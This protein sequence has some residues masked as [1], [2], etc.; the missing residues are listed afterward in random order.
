MKIRSYTV[1]NTIDSSIRKNDMNLKVMSNML[2]TV[3]LFLIIVEGCSSMED[4]MNLPN[5]TVRYISPQKVNSETEKN[6]KAKWKID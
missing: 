1:E 2:K 6:A 3:K 5:N 4:G